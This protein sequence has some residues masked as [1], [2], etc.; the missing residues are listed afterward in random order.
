MPKAKKTHKGKRYCAT[1]YPRLFK[2]RLCDGCGNFAR[3]PVFDLSAR[4]N[5][6]ARNKP[7]ARCGK[8]GFSIGLMTSYGP[9]CKPC[10]PYFKEPEP[11]EA[12]GKLSRRLAKNTQTGLRSCPKCSG[13]AAATCS[14]CRRHRVLVRDALGNKLCRTCHV[15]GAI[16]CGGCGQSMPAGR[17]N[18]CENCYWRRSFKSRLDIDLAGF[19]T[20]EMSKVFRDFGSWLLDEIGPKPASLK[21]HQYYLFFSLIEKHWG[22]IPT[23][24]HLLVKFGA[25]GL[26]KARVPM[27][28]LQEACDI[29]INEAVR[30]HHS[31]T[32]RIAEM[33][34]N[35]VD[36]RSHEILQR[37]YTC[38]LAKVEQGSTSLRSIRLALRPAV[39]LIH[40]ASSDAGGVPVQDTL[41]RFW[42][43]FPGQ[44]A[45]VTGF[46][47][48]LNR[49]FD[50]KLEVRP[51]GRWM[52]K[53]RRQKRER[54][55]ID[56]IRERR[57][58]DDF[59]RK[60]IAAAIA[61]FHG[62]S[63]VSSK[64][65]VYTVTTYKSVPG[66]NVT[67]G[68]NELWVPSGDGFFEYKNRHFGSD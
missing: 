42:Q 56:L 34:E 28:W 1:C 16:A 43:V 55:L 50:L 49:T 32:R 13:P 10:V 2:R 66:F 30:E 18:E 31:E 64:Q 51:D 24:E 20:T 41:K 14:A 47:N 52:E 7:C 4:C 65:L 5:S 58:D 29:V 59:E 3:L 60:W 54:A 27:R 44:L 68:E 11:C 48:F 46:V 33:L 40:L 17:G 63:R 26:R 39:D 67:H 15:Q 9:V 19:R 38:M 12:C 37:Y 45:A 6:C 8:E 53:S 22:Q 23:Y 36:P 62:V 25:D 61:Y 35:V 57:D 21:V